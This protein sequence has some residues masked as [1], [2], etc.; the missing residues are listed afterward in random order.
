MPE[1]LSLGSLLHIDHLEGESLEL[2]EIA[3]GICWSQKE[4][5]AKSKSGI[6]NSINNHVQI[7]L[8]KGTQGMLRQL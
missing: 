8:R 6:V 1:Q 4:V 3:G 7:I 5:D 2:L